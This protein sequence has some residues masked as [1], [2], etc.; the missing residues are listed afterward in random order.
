MCKHNV[1]EPAEYLDVL[2]DYGDIYMCE[3]GAIYDLMDERN[4]KGDEMTPMSAERLTELVNEL[5]NDELERIK[6]AVIK[7]FEPE[8]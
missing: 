2:R 6:I 1:N 5:I 8:E 4:Y 3:C 7:A